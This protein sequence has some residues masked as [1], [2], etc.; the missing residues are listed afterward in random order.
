[1][2]I[3]SGLPPHADRTA[4][5]NKYK[6]LLSLRVVHFLS[7]F[8]LAYGGVEV[9]IGGMQKQYGVAIKHTHVTY[10]LFFPG[11]A[12][13]YIMKRTGGGPSSGYVSTGFFG[14]LALGR[15]ILLW[16]T[17]KVGQR[18]VVFLYS[19]IAIG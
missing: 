19:A 5:G 4:S 15:M 7:I 14:G 3:E 6:E 11:W 2:L 9:T 18:R 12:V 8:A 10:F 16:V 13:N 1:M 17:K